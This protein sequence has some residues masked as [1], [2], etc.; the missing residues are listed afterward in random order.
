MMIMIKIM[1]MMMIIIIITV[2]TMIIINIIIIH[3]KL[4][5]LSEVGIAENFQNGIWLR[6]NYLSQGNDSF[7][8]STYSPVLEYQK[9]TSVPCSLSHV[10]QL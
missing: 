9:T 6:D 2:M 8:S 5:E 7:L 1:V 3:I 10:L 4:A